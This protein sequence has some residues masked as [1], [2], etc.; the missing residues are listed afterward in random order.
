MPYFRDDA[1]LE[2][3]TLENNITDRRNP[4]WDYASNYINK[5]EIIYNI[6]SIERLDTRNKPKIMKKR[7]KQYI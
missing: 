2:V 1:P 3:K 4:V 7:K 5:P 6:K